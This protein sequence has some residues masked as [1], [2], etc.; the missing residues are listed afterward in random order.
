MAADLNA[1]GQAYH[2]S[3]RLTP[4]GDLAAA[5]ITTGGRGVSANDPAFAQVTVPETAALAKVGFI[6]VDPDTLVRGP[7]GSWQFT[8]ADF[9]LPGEAG[10]LAI[11]TS[12]DSQAL[13]Q[14]FLYRVAVPGEPELNAMQT[15]LDMTDHA[16]RGVREVQYTSRDFES[17]TDF[18][19]VPEDE[20]RTFLDT[21]EG[22]YL[23]RGGQIR[24]VSDTGNSLAMQGATLAVDGQ[25]IDKPVCS[26]G[27]ATHPEIFVTPSISAAAANAADAEKVKPAHSIQ[28]WATDFPI[29][30]PDAVQWQVRM[31]VLTSD[32]DWVYPTPD[33]GRMVVFTTCARD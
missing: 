23:C 17:L 6:P 32:N 21:D 3:T 5:I 30:D 33:Y 2:I 22:L 13:R 14:D 28:A 16:I 29:S 25:I 4:G 15:T 8:L 27:S 10:H 20:G 9:N 18:C 26:P 24:V 31:R 12:L 7:Y 19:T 1:W 11:L